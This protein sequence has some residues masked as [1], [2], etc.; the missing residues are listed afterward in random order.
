MVLRGQFVRNHIIWERERER[1]SGRKERKKR[2]SATEARH[3]STGK[4]RPASSPLPALAPDRRTISFVMQRCFRFTWLWKQHEGNGPVDL[5]RTNFASKVSNV[6]FKCHPTPLSE[7]MIEL[8]MNYEL[9]D[10]L[11]S[12]SFV[13][14]IQ[15]C[16]SSTSAS[17]LK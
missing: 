13:Y 4:E 3:A 17:Q 9:R 1:E 5:R 7:N 8:I 14:K 16:L 2:S 6:L 15:I 10:R 12:L 11:R